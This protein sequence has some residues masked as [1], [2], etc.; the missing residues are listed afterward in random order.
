MGRNEFNHNQS[1]AEMDEHDV[2][3]P[4]SNYADFTDEDGFL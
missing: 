4:E 3:S 2:M 1:V